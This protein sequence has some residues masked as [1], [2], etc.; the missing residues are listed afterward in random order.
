MFNVQAVIRRFF[1]PAPLVS[2]ICYVRFRAFV[3]PRAEV[4]LSPLLRIGRRSR[5]S[6]F[7]KIKA[8]HGPLT[9]GSDVNIASGVFISAQKSGVVIGDY[10]MIGPNCTIVS[11][12]YRHEDLE[13]P[14]VQQGLV[15]KGTRIGRNVFIGANSVVVDGARLGSG[16]IVAPGSVVSGKI[17]DNVLIQ[18]NPA[19]VIFER[20]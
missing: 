17:P 12:M 11:G 20:R 15:S 8:T 7:A 14:I 6:S 5:I 19:R 18:G 1:V 9:I 10:T 16:V 3:S 13:K 2:L 4:E